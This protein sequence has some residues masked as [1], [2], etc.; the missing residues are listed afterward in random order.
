MLYIHCLPVCTQMQVTAAKK[1]IEGSNIR[2]LL[3]GVLQQK[4][5]HGH[6]YTAFRRNVTELDIVRHIIVD[7]PP[8]Q[9]L[10]DVCNRLQLCSSLLGRAP[11]PWWA[12]GCRARGAEGRTAEGIWDIFFWTNPLCDFLREWKF[13]HCW[14]RY[15]NMPMKPKAGDMSDIHALMPL[16]GKS[17]RKFGW[18]SRNR[19]SWI[20]L[21]HEYPT[22]YISMCH[23]RG[24]TYFIQFHPFFSR[25]GAAWSSR[26]ES[27]VSSGSAASRGMAGFSCHMERGCLMLFVDVI[28]FWVLID[29]GIA[30]H[31]QGTSDMVLMNATWFAH[32]SFSFVFYC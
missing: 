17:M 3:K 20:E 8:N 1:D 30:W 13:G 12:S 2:F 22:G 29:T 10:A 26:R 4:E 31:C 18:K 23:R 32:W 9:S 15:V 24:A 16:Q 19:H 5:W 14:C 28:E 6:R 25:Q 21:I 11:P 7:I 27:W